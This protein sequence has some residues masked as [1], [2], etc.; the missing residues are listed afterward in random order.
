MRK[1]YCWKIKAIRV[2]GCAVCRAF[3]GNGVAQKM[4]QPGL[5]KIIENE[6]G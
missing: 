4:G 5:A 1:A 3:L 2:E 6:G